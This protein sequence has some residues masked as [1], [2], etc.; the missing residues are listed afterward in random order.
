M[1]KKR[2]VIQIQLLRINRSPQGTGY[3]S[4]Y[5]QLKGFK[6]LNPLPEQ[7]LQVLHVLQTGAYSIAT[8]QELHVLHDPQAAFAWVVA[9]VAKTVQRAIAVKVDFILVLLRVNVKV[10]F[11]LLLLSFHNSTT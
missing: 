9:P 7:V 4:L 1:Q 3:T 6:K 10:K 5:Y 11:S 2:L 8:S